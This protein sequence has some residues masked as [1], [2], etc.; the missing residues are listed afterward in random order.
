VFRTNPRSLATLLAVELALR[1]GLG[2]V[3]SLLTLTVICRFIIPLPLLL[4]VLLR[5]Y[6]AILWTVGWLDCTDVPTEAATLS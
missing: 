4:G 3:V 5:T 2:I 6:L 1:I